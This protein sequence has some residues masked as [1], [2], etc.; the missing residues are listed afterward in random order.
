LELLQLKYFKCVAE[1][2]ML[3]TAAESLYIS[4]P[5]LSASISRLERELGVKL[6]DRTNKSI[7]LNKQGK[8]FLHYVNHLLTTLENAK[9]DVIQSVKREGERISI[10]AT[11]SN[12]WL[13]LFCAFTLE[14]PQITISHSSITLPQLQDNDLPVKYD[15][16]LAS[17]ADI[18]NDNLNSAYLFDD[19]LALMVHPSHRL[20]NRQS[21]DL[22]EVINETIFAPTVEQSLRKML[23][24]LFELAGLSPK[25]ITECS[26]M[27]RRTIVLNRQGISIGTVRSSK[28]ESDPYLRYIPITNP[29][30]RWRQMLLWH[31]KDTLSDAEKLFRDFTINFYKKH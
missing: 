8:I 31:K 25:D 12:I 15:F 24:K 13:D 1:T 5:A 16:L 28:A 19:Q 17:H 21:V 10:A 20:A 22:H 23:D 6:F 2:G 29:H 3:K 7:S 30:Y 9:Q 27:V 4:P 14:Y 11:C 26:Y 18:Q